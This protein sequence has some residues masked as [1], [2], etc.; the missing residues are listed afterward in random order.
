MYTVLA[1]KEHTMPTVG[2][3]MRKLK[4]VLQL[5]FEQN[6]SQHKIAD[7][8]NL[9]VGFKVKIGVVTV[10]DQYYVVFT[11]ILLCTNF[12]QNITFF[13]PKK[14]VGFCS[15]YDIF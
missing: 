9:S 7:R 1:E 4:S 12:S 3:S 11:I 13:T 2:V 5:H 15:A 8:F 6:L 10:H 14:R